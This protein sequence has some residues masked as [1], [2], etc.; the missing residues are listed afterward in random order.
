VVAPA[1]LQWIDPETMDAM[2]NGTVSVDM[3]MAVLPGVLVLLLY[4]FFMIGMTVTG[5][6][7]LMNNRQRIRWP[8]T[9]WDMPLKASLKP[10]VC[11]VGM[12]VYAVL[13]AAAFAW[14]LFAV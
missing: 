3:L 11:N 7:L 9:A 5:F 13:C 2:S 10:A 6:V 12:I 4:S 1:I 14:S 8:A